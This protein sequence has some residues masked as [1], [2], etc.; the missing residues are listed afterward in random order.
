[1]GGFIGEFFLVIVLLVLA[2]VIFVIWLVGVLVR[3]VFRGLGLFRGNAG[4]RSPMML[5]NRLRCGANNPV[6][7]NFCKRCGSPLGVTARGR[8]AA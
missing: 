1:M 7:A 2:W 5:C 6:R 4:K 3:V 8:V